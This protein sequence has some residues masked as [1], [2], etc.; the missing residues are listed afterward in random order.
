MRKGKERVTRARDD[1]REID[2]DC[3]SSSQAWIQPSLR[4]LSNCRPLD[5]SDYFPT[6]EE[7][8]ASPPIKEHP[9]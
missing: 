3:G 4:R 5:H 1:C 8:V 2:R 6:R 9:P 7:L